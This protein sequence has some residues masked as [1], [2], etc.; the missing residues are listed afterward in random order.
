M[1]NSSPIFFDQSSC[2]IVKNKWKNSPEIEFFIFESEI[3]YEWLRLHKE[4]MKIVCQKKCQFLF[5]DMQL[6][7]TY[8]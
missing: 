7:E 3:C 5:Y 8:K 4:I 6:I 2:K 1:K